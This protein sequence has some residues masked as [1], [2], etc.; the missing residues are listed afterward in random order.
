MKNITKEY[1]FILFGDLDGKYKY[2]TLRARESD[3]VL[4]YEQERAFGFNK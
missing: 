2:P 4:D 3:F 1:H